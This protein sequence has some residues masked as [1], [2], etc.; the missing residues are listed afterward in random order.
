[1]VEPLFDEL[2]HP[3]TRLRIMAALAT[4]TELEFSALEDSLG[5]ST[6][7]LSKQLK[8]LA[9][10]RYVRLDKRPQPI[11]RPRTWI[12]LTRHGRAAYDAHV[13]AL[14]DLLNQ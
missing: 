7:L 5:L 13:A 8:M 2:I 10:A 9:E 3:P 14:R 1:M 6:S 12:T 4:A 11:G